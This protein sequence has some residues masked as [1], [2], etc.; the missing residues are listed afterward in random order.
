MAGTQNQEGPVSREQLGLSFWWIVLVGCALLNAQSP[1]SPRLS[2]LSYN[3]NGEP[4]H[5]SDSSQLL[6]PLLQ[7]I[8]EVD[9]LPDWVGHLA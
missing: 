2:P 7:G 1:D 4:G 9:C 3:S 8:D 6:R 5:L